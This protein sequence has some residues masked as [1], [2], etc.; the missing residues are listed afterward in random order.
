MLWPLARVQRTV[1]PLTPAAPAVTVTSPWKPPCHE[2]TVRN[3]AL[4]APAGGGL[5]G[6]GLVGGGLVGGG[7][8]GGG[9][10]G[11]GLV[12][13]GD[14]ESVGVVQSRQ[15]ARLP[16]LSDEMRIVPGSLPVRRRN[17]RRFCCSGV[18]HSGRTA[19]CVP[20]W[21]SDQYVMLSPA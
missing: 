10:V 11:G 18:F 15:S 8:V 5:V 3:E 16:C 2:P 21:T 1:Q 14:V 20:S 13:G 19:Q 4:Q 6:G 7:D 17:L 9:D 12:G